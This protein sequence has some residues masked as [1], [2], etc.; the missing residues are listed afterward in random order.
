MGHLLAPDESLDVIG[1]EAV[2]AA[3]AE[4]DRLKL[5]FSDEAKQL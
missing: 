3:I 5:P 1:A 4:A 2:P